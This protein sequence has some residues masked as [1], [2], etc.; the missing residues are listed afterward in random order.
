M[1]REES[2]KIPFRYAAGGAASREL[3][4][5]RDD[6]V[7]LASRCEPCAAVLS[8]VRSFCPRCGGAE[9]ALVSVGPA[10][11]VASFTS[12]PGKGTYGLVRLDG[13]D[14]PTLHR[15]L[16]DDGGWAVGERVVPRFASERRGSVLDLEGF[17]KEPS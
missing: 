14:T 4:A 3:A 8:P 1:I 13:A 2:I 11:R 10:G 16:G 12:V 17:E 9:L 5:L 7:L 15:L 6:E